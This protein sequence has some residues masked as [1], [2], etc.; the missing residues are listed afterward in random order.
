MEYAKGRINLN[1][2]L[3]NIGSSTSLREKKTAA[4]IQE[5]EMEEQCV[6]SSPVWI[7]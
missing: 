5:W 3:K 1:L 7:I 2:E 4:M 6:V